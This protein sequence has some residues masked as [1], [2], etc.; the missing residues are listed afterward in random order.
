MTNLNKCNKNKNKKQ[1]TIV[2]TIK[3]NIIRNLCGFINE[4]ASFKK[5]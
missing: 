1:K 4:K 5:Y 3:S 2:K